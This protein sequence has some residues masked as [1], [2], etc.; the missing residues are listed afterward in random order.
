LIVSDQTPNPDLSQPADQFLTPEECAEVDRAM[1]TASDRFSA[2]VAIYSLRCL[3][4]IAQHTGGAIADLSP[5]QIASWVEQDPT[6]SPDKG[7]DDAFK[8]F[9]GRLV[10]SSLKPLHQIAAEAEQPIETLTVPQVVAWFEQAA[11]QR[12]ERQM[13]QP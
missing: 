10:I 7:F 5:Q 6:L 1:M 2:R 11:R 3:Q 9:F 13:E 8:V 4:Q 12:I